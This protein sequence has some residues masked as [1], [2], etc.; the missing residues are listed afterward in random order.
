[1]SSAINGPYPCAV[2][3]TFSQNMMINSALISPS[4]Y[5]FNNGAYVVFVSILAANKVR[6]VVEN[7]FD[8]PS[9]T[10]TAQYG[11]KSATNEDLNTAVTVSVSM[12]LGTYDA[13]INAISAS[14]GRL[15]SGK[16][17]KKVFSDYNNWYIVTETGLD[18]VDK[19]TLFN[20][21]YILNESGFTTVF[22]TE[23]E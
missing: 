2:E 14:N 21:G 22:V 5:L 23:P 6:L 3:L 17:A 9:Y 1:M 13:S 12:A 11:L 16:I 20:K 18:V 15:M 19:S 10:I 8:H 7:L 4:T